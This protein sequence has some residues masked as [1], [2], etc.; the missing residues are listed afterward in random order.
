MYLRL[1]VKSFILETNAMEYKTTIRLKCAD[2]LVI[3][4]FNP[5]I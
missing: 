2:T 4:T 5:I 3:Y 1:I